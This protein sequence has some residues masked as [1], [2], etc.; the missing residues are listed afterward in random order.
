MIAICS[1][2]CKDKTVNVNESEAVMRELGKFR[3]EQPY[4]NFENSYWINEI[5]RTAYETD[6]GV[7][8]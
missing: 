5:Y 8:L 1:I 7:L 3:L 4:K 6:I 2:Y